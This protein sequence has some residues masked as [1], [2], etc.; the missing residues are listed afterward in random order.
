MAVTPATKEVK[1]SAKTDAAAGLKGVAS[2]HDLGHPFYVRYW[3]LSGHPIA[4]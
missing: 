3:R 4:R 1:I 2:G